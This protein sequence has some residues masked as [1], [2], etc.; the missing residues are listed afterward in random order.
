MGYY[1]VFVPRTVLH[2]HKFCCPIT[3][4]T[5][6]SRYAV[7]QHTEKYFHLMAA[8][9]LNLTRLIAACRMQLIP[10]QFSRKYFYLEKYNHICHLITTT[11]QATKGLARQQASCKLNYICIIPHTLTVKNHKPI[12][13]NLKVQLGLRIKHG[14]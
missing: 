1:V 8:S 13:D 9:E 14:L 6:Q 5:E 7:I 3:D 12:W 10:L 11:V 4:G 2:K